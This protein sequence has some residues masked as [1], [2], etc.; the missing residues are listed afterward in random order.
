MSNFQLAQIIRDKIV[1]TNL[2][3]DQKEKMCVCV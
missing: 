1:K 3:K 2:K